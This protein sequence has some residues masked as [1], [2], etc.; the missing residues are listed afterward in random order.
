MVIFRSKKF[1]LMDN[2]KLT[3][4]KV[5]S[6]SVF[7]TPFLKATIVQT[8]KESTTDFHYLLAKPIGYCAQCRSLI[9][10]H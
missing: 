8:K 1:W 3:R 6:Y 10:V 9:I 2:T 7:V 5:I 4:P